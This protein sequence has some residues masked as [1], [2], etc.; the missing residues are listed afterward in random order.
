[1]AQLSYTQQGTVR[2][3]SRAWSP[4]LLSQA[5]EQLLSGMGFGN[6]DDAGDVVLEDTAL[7][8]Y[9]GQSYS[10][11]VPFRYPP[12]VAE[13]GRDFRAVH[14]QLYGFSTGEDWEL[15]AI[16][17]SASVT[18]PTIEIEPP[19]A[20]D[21]KTLLPA[22]VGRC[23]FSASSAVD[24]PRYRREEISARLKV[25]GPAIVEDDWST[26]LLPP[27]TALEAT[28]GGHLVMSFGTKS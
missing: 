3:N 17:V 23:W 13:I 18:A 7:I 8:R 20:Q 5:R 4:Q 9:V 22:S 14:E 24:T 12:K 11:E 21:R 1:M 19:C 10:V 27:G 6:G 25:D 16:R 2:M 28:A 26:I 15:E